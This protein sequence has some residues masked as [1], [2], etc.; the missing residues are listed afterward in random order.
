MK[1]YCNNNSFSTRD[2]LLFICN[3][4]SMI[5]VNTKAR[6]PNKSDRRN[7]RALFFIMQFKTLDKFIE[8]IDK[9]IILQS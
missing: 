2:N 3:C 1:S 8:F 4:Y 9:T 7:A 6:L 5:K